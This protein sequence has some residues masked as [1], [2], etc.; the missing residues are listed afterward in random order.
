MRITILCSS[1][2]HPVNAYLIKWKKA[3]DTL[4]TIQ[5]ARNKSELLGGDLL[6]LISASEI[7][8]K[9][10][11]ELYAK[12]LIVH[13]S[14]L[15][16]GRGWSPHVW[17]IVNGASDIVVTLLEAEDKVDSGRIWRKIHMLVGQDMLWDEI[18]D[19]LF[20]ITL[21]MLDFAV[22]NFASVQP[23]EQDANLRPTYYRR[24]YPEDSRLDPDKTIR[25][26]F[27][28]LRVCDPGRFPAFFDL[29]GCRYVVTIRKA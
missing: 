19:S 14:D 2:K 26:Q 11:R 27:N 22:N 13:A 8:A 16:Q 6:F 1:E 18:N 9:A 10:E 7:V 20:N 4:H 29:Y 17:Q 3:N 25:E 12:T 5:V 15:P 23:I 28:L 21:G 24:R